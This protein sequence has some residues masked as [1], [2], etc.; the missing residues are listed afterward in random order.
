MAAD[1]VLISCVGTFGKIAVF[2]N[3]AEK[4]IINPRLIKASIKKDI[5]S[6]YVAKYLKSEVVFKQFQLLSRGGTMGVI[7]IAIL[8][9]IL[10]LMPPQDEQLE[11]LNYLHEEELKFEK[12]TDQASLAV[13]L[14]QERRTALISAAVTGK[15]DVRNWHPPTNK[16]TQ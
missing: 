13:E 6:E 10:T 3:N 1:D 16:D 2:P 15:I 4:G 7:N 11:I 5:E 9:E 12:L 14:L 8:K